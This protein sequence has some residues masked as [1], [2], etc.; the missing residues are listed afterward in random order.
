MFLILFSTASIAWQIA[1]NPALIVDIITLLHCCIHACYY[2]G[3]LSKE[4]K[5]VPIASSPGIVLL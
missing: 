3:S 1:F 4:Q 5:Y 2:F